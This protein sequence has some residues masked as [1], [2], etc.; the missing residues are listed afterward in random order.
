MVSILHCIL[1]GGTIS[2][3][4]VYAYNTPHSKWTHFSR[5]RFITNHCD[6]TF[7]CQYL[8]LTYLYITVLYQPISAF[9][10]IIHIGHIANRSERLRLATLFLEESQYN[11]NSGIYG[12]LAL[13]TKCRMIGNT[14][15][16]KCQPKC[17]KMCRTHM[18]NM[19]HTLLMRYKII[20]L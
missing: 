8:N 18:G 12:E 16:I 13:N 20:Q 3:F 4:L 19:F 2:L 10:T 11:L 1:I 9:S 5:A 17:V 15:A 14:S 6:T 7:A